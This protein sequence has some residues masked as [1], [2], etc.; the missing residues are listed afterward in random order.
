MKKISSENRKLTS[1]ETRINSIKILIISCSVICFAIGLAICI[2]V[3]IAHN[4]RKRIVGTCDVVSGTITQTSENIKFSR[5]T[6]DNSNNSYYY[7]TVYQNIDITYI[8]C[9][10]K[11]KTTIKELSVFSKKYNS[12]IAPS[13]YVVLRDAKKELLKVND[14]LELYVEKNNPGNAYL[15]STIDKKAQNEYVYI[16]LGLAMFFFLVSGFVLF[17]LRRK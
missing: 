17:A 10:N 15:K 14:K 8:Y 9:E 11:H 5:D 12:N 6:D 16:S 1:K 3:I 7:A 2:G 13:D 4:N